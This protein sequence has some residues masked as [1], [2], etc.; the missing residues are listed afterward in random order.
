M[1]V[2]ETNY[3]ITLSRKELKAL[4][5]GLEAL[6]MYERLHPNIGVGFGIESKLIVD[7]LKRKI[8]KMLE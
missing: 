8:D 5:K 7:Q 6:E 4:Q 3:G 2:T 1:E